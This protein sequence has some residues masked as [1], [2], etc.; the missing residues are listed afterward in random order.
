MRRKQHKKTFRLKYWPGEQKEGITHVY[1]A[2]GS[3]ISQVI[4]QDKRR[5]EEHP[6]ADAFLRKYIPGEFEGM[7]LPDGMD[8]NTITHVLVT[9]LEGEKQARIPMMQEEYEA[10]LLQLQEVDL[11]TQR[12]YFEEASKELPDD[13][14]ILY[15]ERQRIHLIAAA[16]GMWISFIHYPHL[17]EDIN[18]I[19]EYA[20]AFCTS[21]SDV[22]P[23]VTHDDEAYRGI[24]ISGLI[25]G[26]LFGVQHIQSLSA[27]EQ[28]VSIQR[29][30]Q[31]GRISAIQHFHE[32][33]REQ[34][35]VFQAK[36]VDD[37][38]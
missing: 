11:K 32:L 13:R 34:L 27:Q 2:Q 6:Q 29:I 1:V 33:F 15:Q 9:R 30:L 5:F 16:T 20:R 38:L 3:R 7:P 23:E 31:M 4:A 35:E 18:A 26:Y 14:L 24:F 17:A 21:M 37:F 22:L 10:Y 28:N 8:I 19:R 36:S 25:A 12:A